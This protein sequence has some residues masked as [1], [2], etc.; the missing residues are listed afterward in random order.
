MD[1]TIIKDIDNI[2]IS[3]S[4]QC[5]LEQCKDIITCPSSKLTVLTQNVRSINKNMDGFT[6]LLSRLNFECDILILTECWLS[7]SCVLPVMDG[8][9][10]QATTN[11]KIQNDG[12]VVYIKNNIKATIEELYLQDSNSLVIKIGSE[13]AILA[14]YRSPSYKNVNRFLQSLNTVLTTLS[15]FSNLSIMGDININIL[16]QNIDACANEYLDLIAFHGL[17]PAHTLPTREGK[18][19]IDHVILKSKNMATT[20]VLNTT[21]TDHQAVLLV[22][23]TKPDK[24]CINS[25]ITKINYEGLGAELA[26]IDFDKVYGMNDVNCAMNYF[27]SSI[28]RAISMNSSPVK[29]SRRKKLV[30]PWLTP[31]L[32]RCLRN[33]DNMHKKLKQDPNNEILKTTYKRYRNY[34]NKI[35]KNVKIAYEKDE[36]NKAGKNTK[37][38]WKAIKRAT[39]SHKNLN[40]SIEL[41]Q[42]DLT[43]ESLNDVNEYF[44]TI[45]E[46]LAS[47]F[48]SVLENNDETAKREP[49]K[50]ASFVLLDTDSDEISRLIMSLR[51]TSSFGWDQIPSKVLKVFKDIFIPPLTYLFSK[52]LTNGIFPNILKKSVIHPIY[53]SGKRDY[54]GNYRPIS[55]LPVISKI[56]ERLINNRLTCYLEN[57]NLLSVGQFG[58]RTGKSTD[59]AVHDLTDW[60]VRRMDTGKKTL[61]IFL[62]LTKAFDTVSI[63]V[64]LH[65]LERIGV[66][67]TELKLF[68]D[69]L[70]D[71]KQCVKIGNCVS[72]ELPITH[73]VPQ[74]SILGPTLFLIYINQLCD[75]P[76]EHGKIISYADDTALLFSADTWKDAYE[77]AQKGFNCVSNWLYRNYLTLN[78]DKTKFINFSIRNSTEITSQL[79]LTAHS[80]FDTNG[81]LCSC[82]DL[83]STASIKYL[84]IIL[85]SNLNFKNHID[86]LVSRLRKLIFIFK[87]LRHIADA[88]LIKSVY[89]A[90][91]ESV[92]SYCI[93]TWGGTFK[94]HLIRLEIAQRAILKVATF[95]PIYF[96]THLLYQCCDVLSVRQLFVFHAIMKQHS[97]THFEPI[98]INKRRKNV[99]CSVPRTKRG[100]VRRF[101]FYLGP[102]LY[103]KINKILDIYPLPKNECKANLKTWLKLLA[104]NDTEG[105]FTKKY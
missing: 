87:K 53:K 90:L 57:N 42:P 45:G 35:L 97:S 14:I 9:Y 43:N 19:C 73:G 70:S 54:V 103:N 81:P 99:V 75:L 16:P 67:G 32:L 100:F 98:Y 37:Q 6:A 101:F 63:H 76:L 86:Q 52:C 48:N 11:N 1:D 93:T 83:N 74:G 72:G 4:M 78:T 38:L 96:P 41:L 51:N 26:K 30:K 20:L 13:T 47:K 66:R 10:M 94:S 85:D 44:A 12:V 40:P 102:L 61:G 80:C 17:L 55:L 91:V 23:Q 46:K 58:F 36:I 21:L 18:S 5:D 82:P 15:S 68:T 92:L 59:Q 50:T 2:S 88:K 60:I 62:D 89:I 7:C 65:K 34:C 104:Y 95:R 31:G 24:I 64:L 28:Q 39:N 22:L 56:L 79:K 77:S 3:N 71:R 27:V 25:H 105:L 29:L 69:Y 84:G 49:S 8:Y 33:R